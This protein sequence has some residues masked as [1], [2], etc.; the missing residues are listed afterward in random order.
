MKF[1][2]RE[3]RKFHFTK[4]AFFRDM[5]CNIK[6]K[7]KRHTFVK[8]TKNS[9]VFCVAFFGWLFQCKN[10]KVLIPGLNF[11]TK[12]EFTLYVRR[13]SGFM[14]SLIRKQ[15]FLKEICKGLGGWV[16]NL[17]T[18]VFWQSPRDN[19]FKKVFFFGLLGI[20]VIKKVQFWGQK[21]FSLFPGFLGLN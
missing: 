14:I 12:R 18:G 21:R 9:R 8:T 6:Y 15:H 17:D 1:S 11:F 13:K 2:S 16:Q 3:L 7:L 20:K 5:K 4:I 19:F 10:P